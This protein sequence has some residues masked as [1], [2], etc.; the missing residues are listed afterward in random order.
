MLRL[1]Y[2]QT[3]AKD[4]SSE[5]AEVDFVQVSAKDAERGNDG[6]RRKL[7]EPKKL[8]GERAGVKEMEGG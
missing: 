3:V 2:M 8:Q 5:G 1:K 4:V 6:G 7:D